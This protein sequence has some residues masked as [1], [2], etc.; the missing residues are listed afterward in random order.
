MSLCNTT[1]S[2]VH[3][4]YMINMY[5]IPIRW[6]KW[7]WQLCKYIFKACLV[8]SFIL[9]K[10]A[11]P[12]K[13]TFLRFTRDIATYLIVTFGNPPSPGLNRIRRSSTDDIR[14]DG[15]KHRPG[16][17]SSKYAGCW[18]AL[19]NGRTFF[20]CR[21]CKVPLHIECFRKLKATCNFC[22]CFLIV[23]DCFNII[24]LTLLENFC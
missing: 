6:K 19:C 18:L 4:I 10:R 24:K 16:N 8:N 3:A 7:W 9:Y 13:V 17:G 5:E 22:I 1:V 11:S 14:L 12:E 23:L 20:V 21:K 2:W 15:M